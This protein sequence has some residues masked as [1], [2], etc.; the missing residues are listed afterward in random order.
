MV[1]VVVV[2]VGV[3]MVEENKAWPMTA[4]GVGAVPIHY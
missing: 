1:V 2:V 4:S 3:A